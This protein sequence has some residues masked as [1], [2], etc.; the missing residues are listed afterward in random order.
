MVIVEES[1]IIIANEFSK[2][3]RGSNMDRQCIYCGVTDNLSESDVFP[4]ALTNARILNK[5][6]CRIDHNN[7]FSDMFESK[8]ITALAF[9]TNEL[10]IKSSKGKQYAKYKAKITI[11]DVDYS[12]NI[13]GDNNIFDGRV[14]K[15]DDEQHMISSFDKMTQIAGSDKA[16]EPLDVNNI[17]IEK[18]VR[19]NNEIFF[20]EAMFRMISKI[21]Y[22][23]YCVRN[24]IVGVHPEFE[25]I[26]RYITEGKGRNPVSIIQVPELYDMLA[27]HTNLGSHALIAFKASA[28]NIQVIVS[29]FGLLMYR[30]VISDTPNSNANNNF[31]FT[32][33]S[34]DSSQKNICHESVDAAKEYIDTFFSPER[35]IPHDIGGLTLMG[36]KAESVK[37]NPDIPLYF[38]LFDMIK[39]FDQITDDAKEPNEVV[40]NIFLKS[41]KDIIQAS[42]IQKKSIKRFVT[43]NFPKGHEPIVLNSN[44]SNKKATV[45]FYAVYL[46]GVSEVEDLND[47]IL[48]KILK[49]GFPGITAGEM[50]IT[51]EREIQLKKMMMDNKNY[52]EVLE[53][54]AE[55]IRNWDN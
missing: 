50:V 45:M 53:K 12:I 29:L 8:V 48:Q 46:V 4:D 25:N 17:E 19:I 11:N 47:S 5:N 24:D 27:N 9:I 49:S 16:V 30:V 6:V 42:T 41:L 43:E 20:D 18:R 38:T 7:R 2:K 35:F 3:D 40:N 37:E 26:I 28:G 32:E 52:A 51:D 54:G 13:H 39:C 22:E 31:L 33:L 21:A 1:D 44:T 10:D 23:W 14:L 34:V 15:S 36:P 55:K